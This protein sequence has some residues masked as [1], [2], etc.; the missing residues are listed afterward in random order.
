LLVVTGLAWTEVGGEILFVE[1][2]LSRGKGN[3]T[4]TGNLGEVMKESAILALEYIK[5]H[6]DYLGIKHE[7]FEKWMYTSMYPKW[8]SQEGLRWYYDGDLTSIGIYRVK[9]GQT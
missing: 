7:V 6:A 5:S 3:L 2:S 9:L 4:L 8:Q 1:T